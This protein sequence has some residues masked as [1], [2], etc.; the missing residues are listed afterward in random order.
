M[1]LLFGIDFKIPINR[2]SGDDVVATKEMDSS[3]VELVGDATIVGGWRGSL[4]ASYVSTS[5]RYITFV[6]TCVICNFL[7][8]RC[9]YK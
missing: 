9:F 7:H 4:G 5:L 6:A 3:H 2:P 1:V 8:W